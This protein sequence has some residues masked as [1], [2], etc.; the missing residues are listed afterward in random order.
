MRSADA[1]ERLQGVERLAEVHTDEALAL[2]EHAAATT[3][4]AASDPR[5]LLVVVR[6]LA[7][8]TERDHARAALAEVIKTQGLAF[9][10]KPSTTQGRDPADDD[11]RGAAR[12]ML[13]RREAAMALAEMHDP[14]VSEDLLSIGRSGE[15]GQEAALDALAVY[16][17]VT[18]VLGG[19]ALTTPATIALAVQVG[20]LRSLDAIAGAARTSDPA[21]RA[22]AIT[23]L[24]VERDGRAAGLA[25]AAAKDTEPRVRVAAASALVHLG[26]ADAPAAVQALIADAA[27]AHEGLR[28]AVAVQGE[29][30]TRAAAAKAMAV[31]DAD[32][33][34][35]CV[36]ALGHQ[37]SPGAVEA[38]AKLAEDPVLQG[39]AA[40]ALA[41]SPSPAAMSAL[42]TM[43]TKPATRRLAAR[44]YYARREMRGARSASLDLV[45]TS[46]AQSAAAAD[47]AVGVQA[48]V[49][50]QP[51]G[52]ARGLGDPEPKVRRAAIMGA[53]AAPSV[54]DAALA[55]SLAKEVDEPTRELMIGLL[56]ERGADS[57]VPT[58]ALVDVVEAGRPG[59]PLAAMALARRMDADLAPRIDALLASSDPILRAHVARGLAASHARDA[60][61]RLA[62]AYAWEVDAEVRRAIIEGLASMPGGASGGGG[63]PKNHETGAPGRARTLEL[64]ARLDPDRVARWTAQRALDGAPIERNVEAGDVAWVRLVNAPGATSSLATTGTLARPDGL[65]RLIAF[66][67]DGYALAVGMPAGVALL[68]LAPRLSAY[69]AP[70]P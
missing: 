29:G 52:L 2:L 7:T 65:A 57:S 50:V 68:R 55:A 16:P 66:D 28:L 24:G 1:D 46:L 70:S 6:A 35:A 12:V 34:V 59:A 48:M 25:R 21:L 33:R 53:M 4:I 64:A 18:P 22:V 14:R 19:V 38:L 49:A 27:T 56:I 20:D 61:G 9:G 26:T 10:V 15:P 54:D 69:D 67:D 37:M 47:R 43:A 17:P 30:I 31:G 3:G 8:W 41:R 39:D 23:A 42:E 60:V 32:L 36:E 40:F 13:A 62:E 45:I 51:T 63:A 11:A 5:A 58:H 44:A